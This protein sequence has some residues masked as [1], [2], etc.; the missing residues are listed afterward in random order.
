MWRSCLPREGFCDLRE[1]ELGQR[2]GRGGKGVEEGKKR[3]DGSRSILYMNM[4]LSSGGGRWG[5]D[6]NIVRCTAYCVRKLISY[7]QNNLKFFSNG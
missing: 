1:E 4:F 6:E 7:K 3:I 2:K 5:M